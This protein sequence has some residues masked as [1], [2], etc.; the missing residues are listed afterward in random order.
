VVLV[1]TH[2][3]IVV[4]TQARGVLEAA[5]IQCFLRNEYAMGAAGELAPIDTW[6]EL[7]IARDH[8]YQHARSLIEASQVEQQASD[9]KCGK[10]GSTSPDTFDWCWHCAGERPA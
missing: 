8:Q 7:W 4:V 1:Y 6:P 5:G 3:S 10:C 2:P 9:W